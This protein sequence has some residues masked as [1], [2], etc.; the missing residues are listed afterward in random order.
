MIEELHPLVSFLKNAFE[1]NANPEDAV[2]MQAYMKS[3]IPFY[4]IKSANYKKLCLEAFKKC[5][6]SDFHEFT[7]AAEQLWNGTFREYKYAAIAFLRKYRKYHIIELLPLLEMM[8]ITGAW[9][10]FVDEISAHLIGT[11]LHKYPDEMKKTLYEWID[12]QS[13]WIRRSAILSQLRLKK[14]TDAEMLFDFCEKCLHEKVFWI[15]KA[16]GWALR[17]FSKTDADA[18]RNFVA[19]HKN[20]MSG[21]TFREA[22][23]YI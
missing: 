9:W 6:V 1:K 5:P 7:T 15:R 8:I 16:I 2:S 19:R 14:D 10:D 18:V 3:E 11:L 17:E 23:K 13:I 12:N 21:L 22:S 4:G 20:N